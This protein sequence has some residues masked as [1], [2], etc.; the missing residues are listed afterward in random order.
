[1]RAEAIKRTFG[2][3]ALAVF[4]CACGPRIQQVRTAV[5]ALPKKRVAI[6][7]F[8]DAPRRPG[9]GQAAADMVAQK[10]REAGFV[11]VNRQDIAKIF[12]EQK[13]EMSGAVSAAETREIGRLSGADYLLTGVVSEAVMRHETIPAD[14]ATEYVSST[15]AKGRVSARPV[16]VVARPARKAMKSTYSLSARLT[17]IETGQ[18]AWAGA[19]SDSADDVS[20]QDVG[21]KVVDKIAGQLFEFVV[22]KQK[23]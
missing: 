11:I 3:M 19:A 13:L 18:I 21:Q 17:S 1:M 4:L 2:F 23:L 12:A 15:D 6:V 8:Q 7:N 20:L 22:E 14:Y 5:D 9:S 16:R 10:L